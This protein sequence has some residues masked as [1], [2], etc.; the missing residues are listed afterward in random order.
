MQIQLDIPNDYNSEEDYQ[1]MYKQCNCEAYED[2]G[3]DPCEPAYEA[4]A[5]AA[6]ESGLEYVEERDFGAV[7][8][9]TPDQIEKLVDIMPDWAYPS[10]REWSDDE[11]EA[12][13]KIHELFK[14]H[15]RGM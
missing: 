10:I 13:K 14:L 4:L 5:D 9:G 11:E 2:T 1:R 15:Y 8:E 6:R 3:C 12:Y 7:W